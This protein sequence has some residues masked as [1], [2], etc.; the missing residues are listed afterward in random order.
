MSEASLDRML[1]VNVKGTF[2][3]IKHTLPLL[4][5]GGG[6]ILITSSVSGLIGH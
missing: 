5:R 2:L 1:A 3:G 6:T 4:R